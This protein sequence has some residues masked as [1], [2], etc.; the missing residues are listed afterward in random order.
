MEPLEPRQLLSASVVS[1]VSFAQS[2]LLSN[3]YTAVDSAGNIY[4]AGAFRGTIDADPSSSVVPLTNTV[5]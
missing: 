3:S 4:F 1:G 5:A 2:D